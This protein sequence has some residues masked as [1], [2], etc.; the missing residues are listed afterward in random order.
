MLFNPHPR[1]MKLV[2]RIGI[3][4]DLEDVFTKQIALVHLAQGDRHP[5]ELFLH[6]SLKPLA[7][8]GPT[9]TRRPSIH[10]DVKTILGPTRTTLNRLDAQFGIPLGVALNTIGV[11]EPLESLALGGDVE[12]CHDVVSIDIF[13]SVKVDSDTRPQ[14]S[15]IIS[16]LKL[17]LELPLH[18]VQYT[19]PDLLTKFSAQGSL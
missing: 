12:G 10:A 8:L 16:F 13:T 14:C 11:V 15:S 5:S 19:S 9:N 18:V 2:Q 6:Q 7:I 3:H 17:K 1:A 4:W